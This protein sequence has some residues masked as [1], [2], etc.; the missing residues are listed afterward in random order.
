MSEQESTTSEQQPPSAPSTP[1]EMS[2]LGDAVLTEME[3][4][5][6]RPSKIA[7]KRARDRDERRRRLANQFMKDEGLT[8]E[9]AREKAELIVLRDEYL[10]LPLDKRIEILR[11]QTRQDIHAIGKSFEGFRQD[12]IN[13]RHNDG[14]LADDMEVLQRFLAKVFARLNLPMLELKPM[15]TEARQ[16]FEAERAEAARL[17]RGA[18]EAQARK[19]EST[20]E[21]QTAESILKE[22]EGKKI[23]GIDGTPEGGLPNEAAYPEAVLFGGS[24]GVPTLSETGEAPPATPL[25]SETAE[26]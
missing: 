21:G 1:E 2:A 15:F 9:A 7:L 14:V 24:D 19:E 10:A 11:A 22:A 26:G 23:V 25:P 5:E 18:E 20:Q 17:A 12:L 6:G 4:R 16:E 8:E 3:K 13:L